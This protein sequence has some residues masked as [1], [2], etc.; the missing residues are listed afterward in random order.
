MRSRILSLLL[1]IMVKIAA[2]K[3]SDSACN[4]CKNGSSLESSLLVVTKVGIA[5]LHHSESP[6]GYIGKNLD[7]YC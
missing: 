4:N 7:Y 2:L 3:N 1:V 6:T 5:A